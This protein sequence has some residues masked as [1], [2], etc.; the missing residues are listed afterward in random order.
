M[1]HEL[2][3]QNLNTD[4]CTQADR[5]MLD[6][7][8][9][10]IMT[11]P[12]YQRGSV[13]TEEQRVGLIKS[14]IQ[15]LPIGALFINERPFPQPRVCVDG[16]QRLET[17]AMWRTNQFAV[18]GEWFDP[19]DLVPDAVTK[20]KAFPNSKLRF[21]DLNDRGQR[22][23]SN[24]WLTAMYLTHLKTEAAEKE[25]YLRINYGGTPHEPLEG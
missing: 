7:D 2:N 1:L 19:Q 9:L 21:R 13:W 11:D 6:D 17:V 23:Q 3:L 14:L 16:K 22:R 24:H 10:R 4:I 20:L 5:T 12:P 18:P 15:G 8:G 25:L